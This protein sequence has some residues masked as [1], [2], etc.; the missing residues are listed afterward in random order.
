MQ[1]RLNAMLLRNGR[2]WRGAKWTYAHLVW[3]DRQVFDEPALAE[4]LALYRGVYRF[5]TR[6]RCSDLRIGQ[7]GRLR[8]DRGLCP[9]AC[10]I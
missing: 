10:S 5:I 4:A 1:Q 6:R 3:I 7:R 2:V 8:Q 9:F